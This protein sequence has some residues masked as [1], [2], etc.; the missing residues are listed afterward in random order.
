MKDCKHKHFKQDCTVCW[1]KLSQGIVVEHAPIRGDEGTDK[2]RQDCINA[3]MLASQ[4][5]IFN[6]TMEMLKADGSREAIL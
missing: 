6:M 3:A 2:H 4:R 5:K 1:I